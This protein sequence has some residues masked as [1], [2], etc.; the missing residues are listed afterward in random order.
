ML[1][2]ADPRDR[3]DE[4]AAKWIDVSGFPRFESSLLQRGR[5][6]SI[7]ARHKR[8]AEDKAHSDRAT[9]PVAVVLEVVDSDG[10]NAAPGTF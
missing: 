2:C 8:E 4:S 10:S 6:G 5:F 3:V 1:V 7:P 9:C